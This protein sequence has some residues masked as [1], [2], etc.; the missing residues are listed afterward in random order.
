MNKKMVIHPKVGF[1]ELKFGSSK[2]EVEKYFGSPQETETLDIEEEDSDVEVWSY[3]DD[4]HAVYFEKEQNEVCT[5]F[6]TDNE[7]ATLF[8]ENIIGKKQDAI[9]ELMNKNGYTDFETEE[10]DPDEL[11]LF[12]H[13]AHLQFVFESGEVVLVSWAVGMDDEGEVIWP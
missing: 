5:N 9:V 3:W 13:D 2:Q 7:Q 1:G 12:Y 4:G 11:I 10:D 6:E 8:G